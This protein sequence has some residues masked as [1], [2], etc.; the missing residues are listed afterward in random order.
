[1]SAAARRRGPPARRG[2]PGGL[3]LRKSCTSFTHR[4]PVHST[5]CTLPGTSS[6]RNCRGIPAA[7]VG[8]CRSPITSA[9]TMAAAPPGRC[10]AGERDGR[11]PGPWGSLPTPP[12][13]PSPPP[14]LGRSV[15]GLALSG[16]VC[17]WSV[18]ETRVGPRANSVAS[19]DFPTRRRLR[20]RSR[21]VGDPDGLGQLWSQT[22]RQGS[23]LAKSCRLQLAAHT[24]RGRRPGCGTEGKG[25]SL[26]HLLSRA[27]EELVVP[28]LGQDAASQGLGAL[29]RSLEDRE[30]QEVDG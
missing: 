7:R 28:S 29:A 26:L 10:P 6:S 20:R 17:E 23:V 12:L 21:R 15:K 5:C 2:G 4:S 8:M 16:W 19:G 27:L 22:I 30:E 9:S 1:M 11:A 24:R 14:A 18:T 25:S 13:C 3:T